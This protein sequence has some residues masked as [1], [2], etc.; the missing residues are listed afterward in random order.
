MR[1]PKQVFILD[2]WSLSCVQFI[3]GLDEAEFYVLNCQQKDETFTPQ[4]SCNNVGLALKI[5]LHSDIY[6]LPE[7]LYFKNRRRLRYR[8]YPQVCMLRRYQSLLEKRMIFT[9]R[10]YELTA[11]LILFYYYFLLLLCSIF[12]PK[13]TDIQATYVLQ[14]FR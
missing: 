14:I 7:I 5:I 10:V 2:C 3:F 11:I 9:Y 1:L 13:Q 6:R 8:S 12:Y 4:V